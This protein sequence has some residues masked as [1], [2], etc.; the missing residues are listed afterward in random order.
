M[1]T[2]DFEGYRNDVKKAYESETYPLCVDEHQV[3]DHPT[4]FMNIIK[5]RSHAMSAANDESRQVLPSRVI[6]DGSIDRFEVSRTVLKVIMDQLA[7]ATFL[8]LVFRLLT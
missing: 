5:R 1:P 4:S 2:P 3:P 6:W 8:M 7:Q